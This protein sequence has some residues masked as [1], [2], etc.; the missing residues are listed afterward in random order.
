[1][2]KPSVSLITVTYNAAATIEKCILSVIAQR[3]E[4]LQYII[5][6]AQSTDGTLAIIGKYRDHIDI[7]ISE[8][9]EGL[10]D[11]MN[12][13]IGLA[14]GEI[15]GM[16]NADDYFANDDIL[17]NV[18]RSFESSGAD[19][20]YGDIDYINKQGK[21]IR[22]WRSG[23]YKPGS[24]NWGWMPPHPSFY[25][26]RQCFT[27]YGLYNVNYGT[28]TDYELMLRFIHTN[29]APVFYL[30]RVMVK[31]L[32]GGLSNRQFSSRLKAWQNDYKAMRANKLLFP[33]F[34]I[35]FKPLRKI[36]QFIP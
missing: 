10:Y 1:M 33:L 36:F 7:V 14:T 27:I 9:D 32:I 34:S 29:K 21:I 17:E 13:G 16:L 18:A 4:N 25:A 3:F 26:R 35:V 28:A 2:I 11:A 12:K 8:P 5:I 22:K 31:M 20:V 15:I 6:D 30:P 19:I 24:F 23:G